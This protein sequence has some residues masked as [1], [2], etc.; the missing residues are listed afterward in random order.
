VL[1]GAIIALGGEQFGWRLCFLVNVPIGIASF[2]LCRKLLPSA[3]PRETTR[4]LD[5]PGAAL[6]AVGVLGLLFPAVEF[7]ADHDVRLFVLA[8]PA[9]AVLAGFVAWERGPARRRG[10]PLIDLSLFR[11]RSYADGVV[12]ALLFF[13]GYTGT[14]IVLA[15]FLQ[16]GLGFSALHSG[17]TA[18][19]YAVG[20]TLA[21]PVAGRLLAR[22]GQKVLVGALVLFGLGVAGSALVAVLVAGRIEPADVALALAPALFVAALALAEV[23]VRGGSTA[24][25][26]L[27]TSQRIG[28]AIGA[29]VITAVFY[30]AVTTAPASGTARAAHYGHGYALS[31]VVSIGFTLAALTMAIRD[32]RRRRVPA[33]VAA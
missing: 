10:H 29:A 27:Q 2:L 25:G 23:D 30:A 21:A 11:I 7:D 16:D 4:A 12:L 5:L 1:G 19:A 9:L 17:L 31:L 33:P 28:N 15:L 32:V 24:G 13:C 20:V 26:M 6:L 8:V 22:A 18:S 3:P 14:P